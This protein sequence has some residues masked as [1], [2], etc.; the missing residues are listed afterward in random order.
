MNLKYIKIFVFYFFPFLLVILITFSFLFTYNFNPTGL[1]LIGENFPKSPFLNSKEAIILKNEIGYDGQQF[2]TLAFD[3]FIL[4]EGTIEALDNP[5][6]RS[7]RI[8]LPFL[9]FILSLGFTQIIPW[10]IIMLNTLGIYLI[11]YIN[12]G[13][14]RIQKIQCLFALAIPGLWIVLKISTA[15]IIA[16]LL[17]LSSYYFLQKNK[18][19]FSFLILCTACL[20]KETM[21]IFAFSYTLS[22]LI[23]K[24]FKKILLMLISFVPFYLWHIFLLVTFGLTGNFDETSNF[25]F[26]LHGIFEKW[27][28]LIFQ[29][30]NKHEYIFFILLNLAIILLIKNL[31]NIWNNTNYLFGA[32]IC[33]ILLFS[34]SSNAIYDYHLSYNRVFIPVFMILLLNIKNFNSYFERIFWVYSFL[35]SIRIIYWVIK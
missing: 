17:V 13:I 3:P 2:L 9:A 4:H 5:R 35:C 8:L 18:L 27:N 19:A 28:N 29:E 21:L 24:E 12:L 25:S 23:K 32:S 26:P 7:K 6:Y 11:Y 14:S 33:Y 1:F 30:N 10:I 34:I 22:L 20:A 16:N 15:E 31:F